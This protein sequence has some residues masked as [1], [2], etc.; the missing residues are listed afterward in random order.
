MHLSKILKLYIYIYIFVC[1][2][3]R[4][5]V[6]VYSVRILFMNYHT[7]HKYEIIKNKKNFMYG[8]ASILRFNLF[9]PAPKIP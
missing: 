6:C 3:A 5:R 8:T 1:A 2:C 7:A 4:A 9:S